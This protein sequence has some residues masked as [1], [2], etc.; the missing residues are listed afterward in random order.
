MSS[1][2]PVAYDG[3]RELISIL[4][5]PNPKLTRPLRVYS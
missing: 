1:P 5:Q 4:P 2:A 3:Y